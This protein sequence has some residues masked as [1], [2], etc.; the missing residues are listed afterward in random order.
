MWNDTF[1]KGSDAMKWI[2]TC[3]FILASGVAEASL[4]DDYDILL[5]KYI[6]QGERQ[7]IEVNLVD[8]KGLEQDPSFAKLVAQIRSFPLATLV[9][10]NEKLAFYINT[11]N[12]L[13][14]QLII[15]YKPKESIR[16]IGNI[17]SGPWDKIVL[18]NDQVKLSLDDIEHKIIRGLDE[19][20]VHFALVCASLSCPDL[21]TSAYR[22]SLLETQ[23]ESQAQTFLRQETKGFKIGKNE[24]FLSKIF[25]W[26]EDDFEK[27]GG[28]R[29]FVSRYREESLV[30]KWRVK[31]LEYNWTLNKL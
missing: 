14:I 13:T 25:D 6:H 29:S 26:Y 30:G 17:F 8:Y 7:G 12:I 24:L 21:S 20:R 4:W 23:L 27:N 15:D 10:R 16:D 9:D 11:Y 19:P 5:S 31:H 2:L 1:I 18:K 28:I 22:A 3:L